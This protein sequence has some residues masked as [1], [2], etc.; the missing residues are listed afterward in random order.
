MSCVTLNFA[1]IAPL[2]QWKSLRKHTKR[3]RVHFPDWLI[4]QQIESETLMRQQFQIS[5]P[6]MLLDCIRAKLSTPYL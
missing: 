5:Q 2:A 3:S 6:S 4:S 1:L